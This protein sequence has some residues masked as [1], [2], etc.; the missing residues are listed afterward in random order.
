MNFMTYFSLIPFFIMLG[1]FIMSLRNDVF[2][3]TKF[4]YRIIALLCSLVPLWGVVLNIGV[5]IYFYNELKKANENNRIFR[6]S[7]IN[8]FLFGEDKCKKGD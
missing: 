8:I 2:V 4:S 1:F 6:N 7:W 5:I 3:E